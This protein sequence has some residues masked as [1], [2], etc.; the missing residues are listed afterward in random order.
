DGDY[1]M[2]RWLERQG[3]S[4]TYAASV[5]LETNPNQL[6]NHKVFLSDFH[7]E[8]WSMPMRTTLTAARDHGVGVAFFDANAIYWQVRFESSPATGQADRVVVCYKDS[9]LDPNPTGNAALTTVN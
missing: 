5:D 9:S 8:Y 7:D 4:L 2:V 6:S 1:N 3:Y